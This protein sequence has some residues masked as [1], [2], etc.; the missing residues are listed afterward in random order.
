MLSIGIHLR[1]W[2]DKRL[3]RFYS[4]R[5]TSHGLEMHLAILHKLIGEFKPRAVVIDPVTNFISVGDEAEVKAMLTRLIDFLKS[6]Q[7]TGVFTSLTSTTGGSLEQT[8]IGISSLMDTWLLLR[9]IEVNGERNRGLYVLKSRGMAHSNQIREFLLTDHGID[10]IDVYLGPDGFF[11]GT[12]RQ[13][14][15]AEEKAALAKRH[16][17]I[18]R[19]ERLIEIKRSQMEAKIAALKSEFE[20]E[21]HELEKNIL[22]ARGR[23]K[24]IAE[25]RLARARIRKADRSSKRN[26]SARMQG[27]MNGSDRKSPG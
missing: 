12:A 22:G 13:T 2:V 18:A 26:G 11:T 9:D 1:P 5:P 20:T 21:K 17:E 7:I 6:Q 27:D 16:E 25:N 24:A 15:E 19:Q 10:L 3:L 14:Q 4:V 23:E 8:N